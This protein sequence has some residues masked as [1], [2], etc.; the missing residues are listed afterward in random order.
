MSTHQTPSRPRSRY[1]AT[2]ED[3]L[4]STR[5]RNDGLE[6]MIEYL[7][8]D[9]QCLERRLQEADAE[10]DAHRATI[11]SLEA[12]YQDL[13]HIIADLEATIEKLESELQTQSARVVVAHST[14]NHERTTSTREEAIIELESVQTRQTQTAAP[15]S[16]TACSI[17]PAAALAESCS[18]FALEAFTSDP[19]PL[20]DINAAVLERANRRLDHTSLSTVVSGQCI[21][22]RSCGRPSLW[23]FGACNKYACWSC[24]VGRRVCMR[25]LG[26]RNFV[27]LPLLPQ[28]RNP[29]AQSRDIEY[30]VWDGVEVV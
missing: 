15:S 7:K 20:S 21:N 11:A 3:L 9:S 4:R 26:E 28:L 29:D 27:L 25:W 1:T 23:P 19:L 2:L 24:F 6:V 8:T 12:G 30:W 22:E 16:T 18:L 14:D 5:G 13:K 17:H 10:C